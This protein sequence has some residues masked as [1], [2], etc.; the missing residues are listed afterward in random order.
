[1][2]SRLPVYLF[3]VVSLTGRGR[4]Q[5]WMCSEEKLHRAQIHMCKIKPFSAQALAAHR[6]AP[7]FALRSAPGTDPAAAGGMCLPGRQPHPLA[8]PAPGRG[9]GGSFSPPLPASMSTSGKNCSLRQSGTSPRFQPPCK[10]PPSTISSAVP[11]VPP[12]PSPRA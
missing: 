2:R 11:C 7:P 12:T 4:A 1:M 8:Y 6:G 9:R 5:N 10:A 3:S